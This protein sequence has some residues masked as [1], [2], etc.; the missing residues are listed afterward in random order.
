M[1]EQNKF[2][3]SIVFTPQ[4]ERFLHDLE[5]KTHKQN[6][7]NKYT[8]TEKFD[9]LIKRIQTHKAFGW[10]C[11]CLGEKTSCSSTF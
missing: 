11:E 10:L 9:W 5:L 4:L 3:V 6:R 1:G 7:N 8:E 2:S